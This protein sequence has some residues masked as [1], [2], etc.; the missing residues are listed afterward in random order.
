MARQKLNVTQTPQSY[1]AT[2][3]LTGELDT[4]GY[5]IYRKVITGTISVAV[6]ANTINNGVTGMRTLIDYSFIMNLTQSTV[7]N[8][9]Q[10]ATYREAGGNWANIISFNATSFV[11][12]SS[13]A[14]GTTA[15]RLTMKYTKN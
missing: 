6:G 12:Q 1:S 3:T 11:L 9:G 15:Y 10:T 2:E 13:F 8:S 14:W 7:S 4:D 5:P